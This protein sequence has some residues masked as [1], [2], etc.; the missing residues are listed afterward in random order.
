MLCKPLANSMPAG[1]VV[2][3]CPVSLSRYHPGELPSVVRKFG[4]GCLKLKTFLLN[5]THFKHIK[6]K[7]FHILLKKG[8]AQAP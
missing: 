8:E 4:P 7:T 3:N 6:S 2:N 5:E 1:T